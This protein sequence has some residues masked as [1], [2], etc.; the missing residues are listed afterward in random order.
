M[1]SAVSCIRRLYWAEHTASSRA[2]YTR[3]AWGTCACV[4]VGGGIR[5]QRRCVPWRGSSDGQATTQHP[6]L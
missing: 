5:G 3:H 6:R 4:C 1:P 2:E